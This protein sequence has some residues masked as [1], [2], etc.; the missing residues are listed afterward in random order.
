L[1]TAE[2]SSGDT[3]VASKINHQ[4][5]DKSRFRVLLIEGDVLPG[6]LQVFAQT[7]AAAIRPTAPAPLPPRVAPAAIHTSKVPATEQSLFTGVVPEEE[8]EP[9]I[10][11]APQPK[12]RDG[13]AKKKLRTP[14]PVPGLEFTSGPKSLKD[15]LEEQQPDGDAKRYL[16]MTWWLRE[17]RQI[18]EVGA[19]HI[20]S[21]YRS[22]N[23]NVPDDV[24]SVFRRLKRQAWVEKGSDPG[25]Y[26]VNHI[27]EGQLRKAA[28]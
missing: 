26:K 21:C 10:E 17:Y 27:G 23:W 1:K 25:H 8:P 12:P 11:P 6:E 7:L 3:F 18:A 2:R 4:P 9:A 20:Y 5:G 13:A 15:Y 22:M 14:Q 28:A 19:D 16:A 24:L